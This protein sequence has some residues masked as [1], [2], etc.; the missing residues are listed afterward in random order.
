MAD[1]SHGAVSSFAGPSV[2]HNP[3]AP[4]LPKVFAVS[5]AGGVRALKIHVP[6]CPKGVSRPSFHRPS[7]LSTMIRNGAQIESSLP[8]ADVCI[9]HPDATEAD[10]RFLCKSANA[11]ARPIPVVH[12][13]WAHASIKAERMLETND[14]KWECLARCKIDPASVT[15]R[16][17]AQTMKAAKHKPTNGI[18]RAPFTY[19]DRNFIIRHL[20]ES[21][22]A[23][24][25]GFKVA[26]ELAR[27]NPRH[28]AASYQTFIS[29]NWKTGQCLEQKINAERARLGAELRALQYAGLGAA[30]RHAGVMPPPS[31]K[32]PKKLIMDD[33]GQVI[34][35]A[36][37]DE[38]EAGQ[39]AGPS[40]SAVQNSSNSIANRARKSADIALQAVRFLSSSNQNGANRVARSSDPVVGS[41]ASAND[42][43]S[44]AVQSDDGGS[45]KR[46]HKSTAS[47]YARSQQGLRLSQ[48]AAQ[49]QSGQKPAEP[50]TSKLA[51]SSKSSAA[52]TS[53]AVNATPGEIVV[54]GADTGDKA[55]AEGQARAN[56][57][58][59]TA[60]PVGLVAR[61]QSLDHDVPAAVVAVEQ[62]TEPSDNRHAADNADA[63]EA[64]AQPPSASVAAV[65]ENG[66]Q[67][68][69]VASPE[70]SRDDSDFSSDSDSEL[71]PVLSKEQQAKLKQQKP[72][73]FSD[74]VSSDSDSSLPLSLNPSNAASNNPSPAKRRR[75]NPIPLAFV[76]Q[77]AYKYGHAPP[78]SQLN[79]SRP[80]PGSEG[81]SSGT[82]AASGV[83]RQAASAASQPSSSSGSSLPSS[84]VRADPPLHAHDLVP[85]TA[86]ASADIPV[87]TQ[88]TDSSTG[89]L[90]PRVKSEAAEDAI[91]EMEEVEVDMQTESLTQQDRDEAALASA[92][93]S[94]QRAR[95][96]SDAEGDAELAGASRADSLLGEF[97]AQDD[98]DMRLMEALKQRSVPAPEA[99]S[100]PSGEQPTASQVVASAGAALA[101]FTGRLGMAAGARQAGPA[102]HPPKWVPPP[103]RTASISSAYA[104]AA[105]DFTQSQ[106]S[107]P[108]SSMPPPPIPALSA[109]SF[110]GLQPPAA[111]GPSTPSA[112]QA[113]TPSQTPLRNGN[114]PRVSADWH[115]AQA[116]GTQAV[117]EYEEQLFDGVSQ[118]AVPQDESEEE[119]VAQGD[120]GG[121]R[122]PDSSDDERD[123]GAGV[124]VTAAE[125]GDKAAAEAA[126]GEGDVEN[127]KAQSEEDL[128]KAYEEELFAGVSQVPV[129]PDTAEAE[130]EGDTSMVEA[131]IEDRDKTAVSQVAMSSPGGGPETEDDELDEL[132][133]EDEAGLGDSKS[134]DDAGRQ[135][136]VDAESQS[137]H[138]W[139]AP[140]KNT[141]SG[142]KA[143]TGDG[144]VRSSPPRAVGSP[145]AQSRTASPE[146]TA[147]DAA[148]SKEKN[149]ERR[150]EKR[151]R[152]DP[153]DS[154]E[155]AEPSPQRLRM[156]EPKQPDIP[157]RGDR[158]LGAFGS[159]SALAAA[160]VQPE[161]GLESA[162]EVAPET[163]PQPQPQPQP[164]IQAQAQT[165]PQPQPSISAKTQA[166]TPAPASVR[167]SSASLSASSRQRSASLAGDNNEAGTSRAVAR[168]SA[169]I[170]PQ[171][172]IGS[173]SHVPF[174][175]SMSPMMQA[176]RPS[177][178]PFFGGRQLSRLTRTTS[179][180]S[181]S[182]LMAG[183]GNTSTASQRRLMRQA[184]EAQ[185][186]ADML[187]LALEF[188]LA[189]PKQ[190]RPWIGE[191]AD[192]DK[193]RE[194]MLADYEEAARGAG[195]GFEVVVDMV[196]QA[197]GAFEKV[198]AALVGDGKHPR[199]GGAARRRNS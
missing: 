5:V 33:G 157:A 83:P 80:R 65:K 50:Q 53:A 72:R 96:V 66:Q 62:A 63:P 182:S 116:L 4:E 141:T 61:P 91:N 134:N 176:R 152:I 154:E 64:Q 18:K 39:A 85:A 57:E 127:E 54:P 183:A 165:V 49:E 195:L 159:A 147:D 21:P 55:H 10:I 37:A 47:L 59:A 24:P 70:R 129:P 121:V 103:E 175:A 7:F 105:E 8:R 82:P 68:G 71:V 27:Q 168:G 25:M 197:D 117:R 56:G 94:T 108:P 19:D 140:P 192:L 132:D 187:T 31:R 146:L 131:N 26:E 180:T 164:E 2:L 177:S 178:G 163:E 84:N 16:G 115:Q 155:D 173:S 38:E 137:Q 114:A 142:R 106:S 166:P 40:T 153:D 109:S 162:P 79:P 43:D 81:P 98:A 52:Q 190:L 124:P 95:G 12:P 93:G 139:Y 32:R 77:S 118:V 3:S 73:R 110:V 99:E 122:D 158:A 102:E 46:I 29:N 42:H 185:A 181:L 9:Y 172:R 36:D 169:H 199:Q 167:A 184:I 125:S 48:Q 87:A 135:Q 123:M 186:R 149:S 45:V 144:D 41:S 111:S 196:R 35:D 97:A 174:N 150:E 188:G 89:S 86:T 44:P 92:E 120:G 60:A 104:S 11:P 133:D 17:A 113:M 179:T 160:P 101:A 194:R 67:N 198:R 136:S 20:L 78:P 76:S 193:C 58:A 138:V 1:G 69:Q 30:A 128:Q 112:E 143:D 156:M 119:A 51:E 107:A 148:T 151:R 191:D 15:G 75:A 22:N 100:A 34:G 88:M 126:D 74:A 13:D 161:P 189:D 130:G 171:S 14:P 90:V 6:D 145:P 170:S 28:S 23:A